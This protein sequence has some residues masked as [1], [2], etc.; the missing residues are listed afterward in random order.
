MCAVADP[1]SCYTCAMKP[2]FPGMVLL[3]MPERSYLK[4]PLL[5][6]S[7]HREQRRRSN[8]AHVCVCVC[9]VSIKLK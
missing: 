4:T 2:Y 9:V 7:S 5:M 8:C 3:V 6:A 1:T